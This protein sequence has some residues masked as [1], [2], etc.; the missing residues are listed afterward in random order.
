MFDTLVLSGG[1][2]KGFCLLGAI[3]AL[4]EKKMFDDIKTFVGTSIGAIISYLLAI[5]YKPIE[6]LVTL[7]KEKWLD[8]LQQ[9]DLLSLINGCGTVSFS[10]INEA[11]EK[12]TLNKIGKLLTLSALQKEYNRTL[13]CCTYNMTLCIT[14][15][16][17][18][19]NYPDI[20][21]LIALRM[22]ANLPLIFERFKYMHSFYID[23]GI[24][25]NFP[26]AHAVTI[27][28]NVLGIYLDVRENSVADNPEQGLINYI[29]RLLAIPIINS[30]KYKMTLVK[31]N[32]TLIPIQTKELSSIIEFNVK[33]K[34]RLDLFS[35]GYKEIM[36]YLNKS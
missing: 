14:E 17:G 19:D 8:K 1:G 18:P 28:K 15:Y 30:T 4:I 36:N 5:G 31:D 35:L 7:Q 33:T 22:S 26:I 10:I 24:T 11:L 2:T 29:L 32:C 21:C 6:I 34:Q 12:M 3:Q 16:I 27:S 23:G 9:F 20:P 13:I 25:D